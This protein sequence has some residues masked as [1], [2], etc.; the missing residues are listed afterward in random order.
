M[1]DDDDERGVTRAELYRKV[2]QLAMTHAEYAIAFIM[3]DLQG[4]LAETNKELKRIADELEIIE[5]QI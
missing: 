4:L 2:G 1:S 5:G 3:L